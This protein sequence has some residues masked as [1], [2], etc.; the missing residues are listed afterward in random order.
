MID[1]KHNKLKDEMTKMN[2]KIYMNALLTNCY[3]LW[4]SK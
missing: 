3:N 1:L 2:T 4:D